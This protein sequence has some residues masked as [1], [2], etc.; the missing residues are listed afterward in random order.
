MYN[1]HMYTI[2]YNDI[3]IYSIYIYTY[4]CDFVWMEMTLSV[5]A[6]TRSNSFQ[7]DPNNPAETP[8]TGL[9]LRPWISWEVL[10]DLEMNHELECT[11]IHVYVHIVQ[12]RH[13]DVHVYIYIYILILMYIYI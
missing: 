5:T 9:N 10:D 3:H 7:D 2:L 8:A 11:C 6:L 12:I 4:M 1:T 13:I